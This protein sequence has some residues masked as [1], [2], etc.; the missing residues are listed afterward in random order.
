MSPLSL[1]W[2]KLL[3]AEWV[4]CAVMLTPRPATRVVH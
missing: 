2:P 3:L 1:V 4:A